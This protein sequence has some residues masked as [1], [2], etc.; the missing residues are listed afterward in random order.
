[1]SYA[2]DQG[3]TAALAPADARTTF[4][5]RTYAN[6]AG[7]VLAFA[8]IEYVIL[9]IPGI[10]NVLMAMFGG[11]IQVLIMF[12]LFVGVSWIAERWALNSTSIE[13]QYA[14]LGLYV[15]VEAVIFLPLLYVANVRFPGAIATAGVLS[16]SVFG[17]LTLAVFTTKKDFS[18]LGPI[19]SIASLVA[20]GFIIAGLIFGFSLGLF[21]S[22]AMVA[23]ASACIL[24]QTS[25]VLHHYRTDQPVAASL[26]LFAAVA[27]LFFYVL[28][29]VMAAQRD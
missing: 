22:L 18:F 6:L 28:R 29:V 3:V 16:L 8:A 21:F 7:A 5:R 15:L 27:L 26:A 1:M 4:I 9:H 13:M 25:N 11:P 23:L 20:I 17:G 12:A 19:I 2:Y 10:E 24:Y 14:G